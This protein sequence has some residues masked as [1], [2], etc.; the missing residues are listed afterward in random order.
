MR[1][2]EPT[3]SAPSA[4]PP[5][6]SPSAEPK[7]KPTPA[8]TPGTGKL[9]AEAEAAAASGDFGQAAQLYGQA[10]QQ[11][12]ANAKAKA[13]LENARGAIASLAK[14]F[15]LGKTQVEGA[16]A[17]S[18]MKAFDTRDVSV[19]KPAE[20][21]GRLEIAASP[22]HVKPGDALR[23]QVFLQ[24]DGNKAIR[25]QALTVATTVD[26]VRQNAPA[27]PLVKE[28]AARQRVLVLEITETWKPVANVWR[29]EVQVTSDKGET[30][31][32]ALSWK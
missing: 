23:L 2:P 24:N 30:Y 20:V 5:P 4:A 26:T 15:V 22:E 18:D 7:P 29:L 13:G 3:A 25:L 6:P 14:T 12:P 31:T 10:L 19:R 32:N 9:Q 27:T 8:A 21:P 16:A 28:V 1:S 11:E 17:R